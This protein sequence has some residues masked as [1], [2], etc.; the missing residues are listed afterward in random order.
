MSQIKLWGRVCSTNPS[1]GVFKKHCQLHYFLVC[2]AVMV[3]SPFAKWFA[4]KT[5]RVLLSSLHL[6]SFFTNP[7]WNVSCSLLGS[8]SVVGEWFSVFYLY[9][10]SLFFY[11]HSFWCSFILQL[12]C[13]HVSLGL[14]IHWLILITFLIPRTYNRILESLQNAF[15]PPLL[16]FSISSHF[17][18]L[19]SCVINGS[20][21]AFS[22]HFYNRFSWN[23]FILHLS[24]PVLL[25]APLILPDIRVT[26]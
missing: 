2:V 19:L 4:V 20:S 10:L 8:R 1:F 21:G 11:S 17:S 9:Y 13:H 18:S 5:A 22:Y 7:Q 15:L 12:L 24:T 23:L 3:V 6:K 16:T 26:K 25:N 14:L